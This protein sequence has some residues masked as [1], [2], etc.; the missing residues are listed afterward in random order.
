MSSPFIGQ[1]LLVGFNFAP[2]GWAYCNGNL[3]SIS[4]FSTLYNLIGTTY[5]G[6]GTSDFALPNLLSRIPIHQGTGGGGTYVI[7]QTAGSESVTVNISQ[8][9]SHTHTLSGSSNTTPATNTPANSLVGSGLTAFSTHA[10]AT[11]MY[12]P[13]IGPSGGGNLPHE[14]LQP[15]LAMNWVIALYGVYPSQ[16]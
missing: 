7:G 13:M 14:N 9:P 15:Y 3:L 2:I 11:A 12:S 16:S 5:G 10:P 1:C 4:E 8:F 6:N